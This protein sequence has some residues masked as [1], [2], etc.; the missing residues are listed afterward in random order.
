MRS[1]L[2]AA[3]VFLNISVFAQTTSELS[4]SV[5]DELSEPIAGAAVRILNT[6]FSTFT[7][8]T[9]SFRFENLPEGSYIVQV[10]AAG[11]ASIHREIRVPFAQQLDLQLARAADQLDAVT[12]T[13]QKTEENLQRVPLSISSLPERKVAEY[14]LWDG[15]DLAAIVPNLYAANPGDN[16]NVISI[17]GI[18]T[19]SYDPA[20][21][22]YIDGVSQF[23]LDTYIAQLLDIERIEVLRGPQGTL[24]GRNSM[25]GVVNIITRQPGNTTRGYVQADIGNYGL[26][27]YSFG[28]QTPLIAN[29]LFLGA[30]GMY[31][32]QDGYYTNAFD[33]SDYDKAHSFMGNYY[34]KYLPSD[35]WALTLN[36]KHDQ[37]RNN[38]AFPLV[39][40]PEVA[41]E[42]PFEVNQNALTELVDNIFNASFSANYYGEALNFSSQ[43]AWQSNHRYYI[44]PIDGDFSPA[45]AISI[46]NNYGNDWNNVKVLTQELRLSS[47]RSD[48]SRLDW[49]AGL[50][51]FYQDNP[52]R[53]GTYIG[54]DAELAGMPPSLAN[55][56]NITTNEGNGY[57]IAA[58]GQATYRLSERLAVTAG[59]RFDH[60]RKELSV[61]GEFLQGEEPPAV[62]LPDTAAEASFNA[63][64]PKLSLAY[65]ISENHHAYLTYSRGFRAGGITQYS[66]QDDQ[67]PLYAYDPE[68]SGNFEA[69]IKNMLADG[70]L[71]LN[72][73]AFYMNVSDAQVPTL[74]LPEAITITR[75]VGEL[76]SK[77]LEMEIASTP[78][79]GLEA[80]WNFGYTDAAYTRLELPGEESAVN[81]DGNRQLFT[82]ETTSMLSLQY[83]YSPPSSPG[84][85][86]I[87]GGQ[88]QY[89]GDQYFDL[90][91]TI[92]QAGYHLFHARAGIATGRFELF[93]WGR[94]ILDKT[95]IDYAYDFGATHLGE[96]GTYGV[97]VTARL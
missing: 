90:Q 65:D 21:T 59:L 77:G 93:L 80:T 70:K 72:F 51:G 79:K 92:E 2:L 71:R 85:K 60:E 66:G 14:Q 50:Y 83:S 10:S 36:V 9:G 47:V 15:K 23:G 44:Q 96:P 29:K 35:R 57:G 17:R 8:N 18:A 31:D 87:A 81:M 88:W 54:A 13:A 86:L 7:E 76:E 41:L 30:A 3:C 1:F 55:T 28:L 95:Y 49:T 73:S 97:S 38:G 52:V 24:Y 61:K 63:F 33:G 48:D 53:Q 22:T 46:V 94:N 84:L 78:V 67:P 4:G 32:Q 58:Y 62:I 25:G 19:T 20:V 45:D 43:T 26:Q 69:G 11:Y 27:R 89:T 64:S 6:N 75:N 34:L 91:N 82:P 39:A 5:S 68:Y 37:N 12:V 42:N 56:T 16:R 40:S 74:I